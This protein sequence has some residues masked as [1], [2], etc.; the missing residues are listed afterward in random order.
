MALLDHRAI[1]CGEACLRNVR[2]RRVRVAV[3]TDP[4]LGGRSRRSGRTAATTRR[5]QR[6]SELKDRLLEGERRLP[7]FRCRLVH[8]RVGQLEVGAIALAPRPST[9]A[10]PSSRRIERDRPRPGDRTAWPAWRRAVHDADIV[11]SPFRPWWMLRTHG[12]AVSGQGHDAAPRS[13]RLLNGASL[14]RPHPRQ[15]RRP[16]QRSRTS[17]AIGRRAVPGA[18]RGCCAASVG[19][20][21]EMIVRTNAGAVRPRNAATLG[22]E[23]SGAQPIAAPRPSA[24]AATRIRSAA[25][26]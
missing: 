11:A 7:A 23:V 24:P 19:W 14:G 3:V 22:R 4:I 6:T 18:E 17:S 8:R 5:I 21:R 12:G 20:P 2:P 13:R 16:P 15:P 26:P 25:R 10:P 9:H 1:L